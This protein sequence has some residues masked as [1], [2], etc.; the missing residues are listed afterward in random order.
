MRTRRRLAHCLPLVQ[1]RWVGMLLFQS[2]TTLLYASVA[3]ANMFP[4]HSRG[5]V[6]ACRLTRGL[7]RVR[8]ALDTRACDEHWH[9]LPPSER[10]GLLRLY[11][12]GANLTPLW[13]AAMAYDPFRVP[14]ERSHRKWRM[15]WQDHLWLAEALFQS[16][17]M[18]TAAWQILL[19]AYGATDLQNQRLEHLIAHPALFSQCQVWCADQ[20]HDA[21]RRGDLQWPP[22]LRHDLY[23]WGLTQ[24]FT[25]WTARYGPDFLPPEARR[26]GA[27]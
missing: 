14:R 2:R 25:P 16:D 22:E 18:A 26:A 17:V 23:T 13:S 10:D 5:S 7:D 8:C 6:L 12:P 19:P 9:H 4:K 1:H 21:L 27:A 20:L 3:L 15:A 11:Y 24:R